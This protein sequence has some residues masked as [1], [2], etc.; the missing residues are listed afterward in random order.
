MSLYIDVLLVYNL[1]GGFYL[2]NNSHPQ[3]LGFPMNDVN[4][5]VTYLTYMTFGV[6]LKV[7]ESK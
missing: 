1:G 4:G 6:F 2:L 3:I 5:E 7:F